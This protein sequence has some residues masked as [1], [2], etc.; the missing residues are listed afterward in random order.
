M[1]QGLPP[2]V[3]QESINRAKVLNALLRR[4]RQN[5]TGLDDD[6]LMDETMGLMPPE[7]PRDYLDLDDDLGAASL[8]RDEEGKIKPVVIAGGVVAGLFILNQVRKKRG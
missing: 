4:R 7:S 3:T 5:A 6:M 8:F 1:A 2:T